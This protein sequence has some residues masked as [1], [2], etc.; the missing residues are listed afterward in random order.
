MAEYGPHADVNETARA[1][2]VGE[3]RSQWDIAS[4]EVCLGQYARDVCS[5]VPMN[6]IGAGFTASIE[7][8]RSLGAMELLCLRHLVIEGKAAAQAQRDSEAFLYADRNARS[9]AE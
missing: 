9:L 5:K 3:G 2:L 7:L 8:K 6:R 4:L 1:R